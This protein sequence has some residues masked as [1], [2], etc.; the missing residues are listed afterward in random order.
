MSSDGNPQSKSPSKSPSE[1]TGE[2]ASEPHD[3][4]ER[5]QQQRS[6]QQRSEQQQSSKTESPSD[7]TPAA[8]IQ[9]AVPRNIRMTVMYDGTRYVG[10]QIQSNGLSLQ[11][12]LQ[13]AV[14]KLT[15][16]A[17]CVY[18]A[19]RT[20]SGVH[21]L[22]QVINFFTFSVIPGAAFRGALQACL[23]EDVVVLDSREV[24]FEFHSTYSAIRKRYRYVINNNSVS[25][26][27]LRNYTWPI[28]K[29]IS[30]DLMHEAG[31]LLLGTHDFRSFETDWP[32]KVSS[33]RTVMEVTVYRTTGWPLWE[34]TIAAPT[35]GAVVDRVVTTSH[36]AADHAQRVDPVSQPTDVKPPATAG[37][38]V[39]LE[40]VA[41]GFLYNMVRC[42]TGTLV[43]VGRKKWP[44]SRVAEILAAQS[45]SVAGN[46][47][48][49]GGLYLV[50]VDYPA[51]DELKRSRKVDTNI[52]DSN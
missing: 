45:R 30:A 48:P 25:L 2:Q 12:V 43:M 32:N 33:V 13:K 8:C 42:I 11:E 36:A 34:P 5:S 49:P 35:P 51:D 47:A 22:G 6:Q 37:Q 18:S 39:C 17:L 27:M 41:D 16:E 26:P 15:G 1:P 29:P 31:Q 9:P 50:Q 38:F 14:K 19:G 23:P 20:D 3:G 24:P 44:V 21:A 10:W 40:I 52:P 7:A 46:T 28:R 4:D